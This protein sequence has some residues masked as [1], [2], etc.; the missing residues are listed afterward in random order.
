MS[1][2]HFGRSYVRWSFFYYPMSNKIA[3][4]KIE[5]IF[6]VYGSEHNQKQVISA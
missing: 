4:A 1:T 2:Y 6:V 5:T 3:K